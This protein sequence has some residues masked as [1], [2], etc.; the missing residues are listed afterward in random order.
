M[1]TGFEVVAAKSKKDTSDDDAPTHEPMKPVGQIRRNPD[2]DQRKVKRLINM[3]RTASSSDSWVAELLDAVA[4][5]KST[6][7]VE[8]S[9]GMITHAEPFYIHIWW[10]GGSISDDFGNRVA[11]SGVWEVMISDTDDIVGGR[12]FARQD[13]RVAEGHRRA[14]IAA[15]ASGWI[16]DQVYRITRGASKVDKTSMY[17]VID[18]IGPSA[19][20]YQEYQAG[21]TEGEQDALAGRSPIYSGNA[22]GD[23]AMG[24]IEGF[25]RNTGN[26]WAEYRAASKIASPD[27]EMTTDT[28]T[29][30]LLPTPAQGE[31]MTE[32]ETRTMG[33][34][35]ASIAALDNRE[36]DLIRAM[37]IASREEYRDLVLELEQVRSARTAAV[38][39]ASDIETADMIVRDHLTPRVTSAYVDQG[40]HSEQT[41]WLDDI[42]DHTASRDISNEMAAEASAWFGRVSSE[43][44]A[45][46]DEFVEQAQGM[47]SVLGGRYGEQAQYARGAFLDHVGHLHRQATPPIASDYWGD[48][49]KSCPTCNSNSVVPQGGKGYECLDCGSTFGG[50]K[51]SS[52]ESIKPDAVLDQG[53]WT[54]MAETELAALAGR[55]PMRTTPFDHTADAKAEEGTSIKDGGEPIADESGQAESGLP[56]AADTPPDPKPMDPLTPPVDPLNAGKPEQEQKLPSATGAMTDE[57]FANAQAQPKVCGVCDQ[58]IKSGGP[59]GGSWVHAST[60]EA[61][62]GDHY[63]ELKGGREASR[64]AT[65]R[66]IAEQDYSGSTTDER[67]EYHKWYSDKG[68]SEG[69]DGTENFQ[70]WKKNRSTNLIASRTAAENERTYEQYAA[71]FRAQGMTPM[72]PEDWQKAKDNDAEMAKRYQSARTAMPDSKGKSDDDYIDRGWDKHPKA[73]EGKADT[74]KEPGS[75]ADPSG[76]G[77]SGLP[78]AADSPPDSGEMFPWDLP[79][80]G[81]KK[82]YLNIQ[83][84]RAV[85]SGAPSREITQRAAAAIVS[86]FDALSP[87]RR[88]AF[89]TLSPRVAL[90]KA[91]KF[92]QAGGYPGG[93]ERAKPSAQ[94]NAGDIADSSGN[95]T[96]GLMSVSDPGNPPDDAPQDPIN[97]FGS[98]VTTGTGAADVASVATPGS[99]EADY[100]QPSGTATP[101]A[102]DGKEWTQIES[103]QTVAFRQRCQANLA[104]EGATR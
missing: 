9:G 59:G 40:L 26:E 94:G 67:T 20:G 95:A 65:M 63:A 58:P 82:A 55:T 91:A 104:A 16:D 62:S 45:D 90:A 4:H 17:D 49:D 72:S 96:S 38:N 92:V 2:A 93:D 103:P 11:D 8:G 76:Q 57:E 25:R 29:Y 47:A 79:T 101:P 88:E 69:H 80:P 30:N 85:A 70:D 43:V 54:G 3:G 41:D 71:S 84:L 89:I 15:Y 1:R 31:E 42:V 39:E 37:S 36:A 23:Y 6:T 102:G 77:V 81:D 83:A 7:R 60:G 78:Q 33:S 53:M 18:H 51:K 28:T 10:D 32:P 100:P 98:A 12:Q 14:E 13:F 34:K 22:E 46:R 48:T 75:I 61:R 68:D 5:G 97:E 27:G 35:T 99:S 44:K 74:N 73:E 87:E 64:T 56:Q 66:H 19:G 24:Y 52:A 86:M 21:F 50:G